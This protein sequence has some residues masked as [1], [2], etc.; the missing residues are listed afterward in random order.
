MWFLR[1]QTDVNILRDKNIHIWDGNSTREFLDNNGFY[2]LPEWEIGKSYG[3]QFRNSGGH[4]DQLQNTIN[5]IKSNPTSR[6]IIINLWNPTEIDEMALPPC[7]M[8]YQFY[9][10]DG[11]YLSCKATQRSSDISLAGGWN[12]AT[13][14]LFTIMMAH[15]C[16]LKPKEII[17]SIGDAHIYLNQ[18]DAVKTQLQR[19]PRPFP[20]LHVIKS[21]ENNDITKFEYNHFRL[22][23][24]T[25][26][27]PIKLS[28][29]V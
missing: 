23:N 25:P 6:R 18:I 9:V 13:I 19:L 22:D 5:L 24:Y 17:W 11:K 16:E 4:V 29:N 27:P 12:I 20:T 21:P 15:V 1:G 7:L 28:M 3:Y 14:S 8:M 10:T 26:H 2:H